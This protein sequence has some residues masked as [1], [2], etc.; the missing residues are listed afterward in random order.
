V[1]QPAVTGPAAVGVSQSRLPVFAHTLFQALD[2]ARA[3]TQESG[4]SGTRHVSLDACA[5][6]THSLQFLLTQREC[7]LSHRVTFSRCR[8]GA[9]ELWS[10]DTPRSEP[11]TKPLFYGTLYIAFVALAIP[12]DPH[13]KLHSQHRAPLERD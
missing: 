1:R 6:Y 4:G 11:W 12:F 5:D 2:L 9:T 7:L 10:Y 13:K 8:K 3:Q